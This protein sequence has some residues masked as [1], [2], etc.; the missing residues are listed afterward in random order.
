M[1][2][3]KHFAAYAA[4]F[5]EAYE[6]DDWSRVESY[7]ADD[8]VYEIGLPILG[9]ERCE[10]RGAIVAWFKDV[11]DRFDRRFESRTLNLLEGPREAG[12][13][14]WIKG[15]ATYTA[16]GAPDLVLALE[17]TIRFEGEK[18]VHLEDRYTPE[19]R[20]EATRYLL[21]FGEAL[22]IRQI[23]PSAAH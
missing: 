13:E 19:M 9:A 5:E 20:E 3:I 17:E 4:A 2:R 14:I 18:I 11:L 12:N 6:S 23:H 21:E 8:A 16:E 10:G 22:G 7:F 1:S 15:T